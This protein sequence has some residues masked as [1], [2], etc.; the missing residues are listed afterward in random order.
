MKKAFVIFSLFAI[1]TA[2]SGFVDTQLLSEDDLEYERI[3]NDNGSALSSELESDSPWES[4]NEWQCFDM[5]VVEFTCANYDYGT[6]VPS[7]SVVSRNEILVFDTHVED[8]LN[9]EQT[10]R[11]WQDLTAEGREICIFAAQM[12]DVDLGLDENKPQSLWYISRL[13]GVDGYWNLHESSSVY[14]ENSQ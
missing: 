1:C 3:D 12:P 9:C 5:T 10:L 14:D 7:I 2:A 4:Y 6:L 8:R 13:K 11:L